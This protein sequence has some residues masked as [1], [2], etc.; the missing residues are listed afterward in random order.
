VAVALLTSLREEGH[1]MEFN[2]PISNKRTHH[3]PVPVSFELV[4]IRVD[5]SSLYPSL[6]AGICSLE[7]L[8]LHMI[9]P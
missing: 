8:L 6:A 2:L 5:P 7:P 9:F 1:V 3:R 4:P